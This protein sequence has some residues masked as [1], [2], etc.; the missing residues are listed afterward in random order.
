MLRRRLPTVQTGHN[1]QTG[2]VRRSGV[3][4]RSGPFSWKESW[5]ETG[6]MWESAPPHWDLE[7]W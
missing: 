2:E 6:K 5:S 4:P 1:Q 3:G 7:T